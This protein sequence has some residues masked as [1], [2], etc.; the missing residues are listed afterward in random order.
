M[1]LSLLAGLLVAALVLA[2]TAAAVTAPGARRTKP[3]TATGRVVDVHGR[4]VAGAALEVSI[5]N[6]EYKSVTIGRGVSGADG[7]FALR[8]TTSDYGDAG[9]GVDAPGF[10]HWGWVFDRG[11]VDEKIV[12]R[13]VIDRP[14]I[15]GLREVRD[16]AERA[17]RV[18]EI[19]ASY[20]LPEI[21]EMFPY[22]GEV[23]A[24]L[25]AIVRAGTAEPRDRR[26]DSSPAD[27]AARLL[28][29]WADPADDALVWPWVKKNWGGRPANVAHLG[30][31]GA[32]IDQV[33]DRWREIHFDD[34][35]VSGRQ[36]WSSCLQPV[37]DRTG[38]HALTRFQVRYAYWGYDMYLV[39]RRDGE[40]WV[41]RGVGGS[42]ILHFTR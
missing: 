2:G 15:E 37:L 31:S 6:Q 34:Q 38:N 20:D 1:R 33:C 8:L 42:R 36:P 22:L 26:D 23:R 30:L 16:P 27:Q 5:T 19:A 28:A 18:L 11:V 9:L 7:R 4:P 17:R 40:R 21:A 10:A 35:K 41:L 25:A 39:M 12:L 29:Y 14:F 24:E 13:R 3:W 32:S